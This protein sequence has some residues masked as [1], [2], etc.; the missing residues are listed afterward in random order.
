MKLSEKVPFHASCN[1]DWGVAAT[2][3]EN[4][5]QQITG[6]LILIGGIL[7]LCFTTIIVDPQISGHIH[8]QAGTFALRSIQLKIHE[9]S[10]GN[11]RST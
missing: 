11:N 3:C 10:R 6:A 9:E 8:K 2:G 7:K 4:G 1:F 5:G